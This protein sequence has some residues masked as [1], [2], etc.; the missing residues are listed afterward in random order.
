MNINATLFVQVINFF[1]AH[2]MLKKFLFLPVLQDIQ[3]ERLKTKE[4]LHMINEISQV[5]L[6]HEQQ[7]KHELLALKKYF[8]NT[9]PVL[10]LMDKKP[11]LYS[12][13]TQKFSGEHFDRFREKL[14]ILLR[15]KLDIVLK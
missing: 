2:F 7:R 4:L 10:L 14:T 15:K 5:I 6:Q 12:R 9:Q 11:I 1:I 13:Y 3:R 8:L